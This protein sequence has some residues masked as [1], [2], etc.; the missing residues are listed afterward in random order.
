MTACCDSTAAA[1]EQEV[2]SRRRRQAGSRVWEGREWKRKL[3]STR[4]SCNSVQ[5]C[6][7]FVFLTPPLP[8]C[9]PACLPGYVW[10]RPSSVFGCCQPAARCRHFNFRRKCALKLPLGPKK[11]QSQFLADNRFVIGAPK[12][13]RVRHKA[14]RRDSKLEIAAAQMQFHL[15]WSLSIFKSVFKPF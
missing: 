5:M 6:L 3:S 4:S 14:Q 10:S 15:N 11:R 1:A 13:N 12:C 2:E 9:L 8:A 7:S